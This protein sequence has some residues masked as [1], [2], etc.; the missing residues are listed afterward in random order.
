MAN[1]KQKYSASSGS[2]FNILMA[3]NESIPVVGEGATIL[4]YTDREAYTVVDFNPKKKEVRIQ[5]CNPKRIDNFG[6]SE[7]QIYDYSEHDDY[8]KNLKY[9]YNNWYEVYFD[10]YQ[11]KEVYSKVRILFGVRDEYYDFSF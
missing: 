2:F 9:R 6:M 5:K 3:N 7:S 8:F 11:D 10:A 1:F 4:M